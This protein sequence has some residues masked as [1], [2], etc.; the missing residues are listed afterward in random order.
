MMLYINSFNNTWL[1]GLVFF[2]LQ[3]FVFGYLIFKSDYIPGIIEVL[4]IIASLGYL[5]G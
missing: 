1:I 3:L 4:L 5:I 2:A